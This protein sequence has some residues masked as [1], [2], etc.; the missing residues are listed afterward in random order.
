MAG[1]R[2][3]VR[4]SLA[5]SSAALIFLL[6]QA[7]AAMANTVFNDGTWYCSNRITVISLTHSGPIYTSNVRLY[8]N[9]QLTSPVLYEYSAPTLKNYTWYSNQH[10]SYL[11]S[12]YGY[13]YAGGVNAKCR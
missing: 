12:A 6:S 13:Y 1:V 10:L 5:A 4:R 3:W 9:P 2:G 7:P 11:L 8:P